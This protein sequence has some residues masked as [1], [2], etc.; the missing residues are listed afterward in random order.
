L[1]WRLHLIVYDAINNLIWE[2]Y[3]SSISGDVL[4]SACVIIW[5]L[6]LDY[7]SNLRGD[8]CTSTDAAG[9][10]IG[11]IVAT[12]DEVNSGHI[13]H[14][15]RLAL[16]NDML[17]RGV[18]AHPATHASGVLYGP[19]PSPFY[20]MRMR[21]KSSFVNSNFSN[22]ERS[23]MTALSIIF[24]ALKTYGMYMADGSSQGVGGIPFMLANDGFS[25]AK[26]ANM[27]IDSHS[28]FGLTVDD[29]EVLQPLDPNLGPNH[30]GRIKLTF[31]C[32]RNFPTPGRARLTCGKNR[33]IV[34]DNEST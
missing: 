29:F 25:T 21:L 18:Y 19:D 1:F 16:P 24:D 28:L 26:W 31:D 14:A 6:T 9:F 11:P 10:A 17:Q 33:P 7:P 12:S 23:N 5:D 4:T 32:K 22:P 8:Q 27:N 3:A 30:D 15:L 13:N 34:T 2:S 20:G